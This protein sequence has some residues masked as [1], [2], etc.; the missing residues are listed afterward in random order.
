MAYRLKSDGIT[1]AQARNG[2]ATQLLIYCTNPAGCGH[3]GTLPLDGLDAALRIKTL[4]PK[5][6][7]AKCGHLGGD[8]RPDYGHFTASVMA[9]RTNPV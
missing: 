3:C 1:V 7:C 6:R 5:A 2:G 8:V 4:E 9:H